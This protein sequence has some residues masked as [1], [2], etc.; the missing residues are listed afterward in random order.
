VS[1]IFEPTTINGLQL[2]NRLVRSATWEGLANEEG[3]VTD[4]LI[5]IYKNL[6]LGQVGLIIS[7]YI[8]VKSDGK[9]W[10]SQIG[11]DND[12]QIPGL[13]R[14]AD[15]VHN[16]GGRLI[17]QIVHCGGQASRKASGDK[18]PVAPSA[19]E[20]PG[21]SEM[22]R[23]LTLSEI[24]DLVACFTSAANR[25]KRANFDGV[26]LHC[27]H[28]YLLSEFLSPSRNL[29]R[30]QFGGNIE[31]RCRFA[32]EIYKSI[33]QE[34]GPSFPVIIKLNAND[35][36]ENSTT[37]TDASALAK[38]LVD[39]GLDA[40][41]ISGGT[42]GSGAM[43]PARSD[44]NSYDQE[45]YFLP[46]AKT[47][48]AAVPDVPLML[49]GG[50]RSAKK[51]ESILETGIADYFSMSR[52]LIRQPHLP[53]LWSEDNTDKAACVSCNQCFLPAM[54]GNGI[55]CLKLKPEAR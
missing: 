39:E 30:D 45:A 25:L 43:G 7:S 51:I 46:Q 1:Q 31:N 3:H 11:A 28:G 22:P 14:L 8:Y 55:K 19:V 20:S 32:T 21:Y 2:K 24:D 50:I 15:E 52:P 48:R 41:E 42:P 16:S 47:I 27:A 5:S 36:L 4:E 49:V 6:A 33:R 37:E 40:I 26:Q 29:R 18:T 35:F 54:R 12:K 34:V 17:G 10:D 13:R 9:Q 38:T 44:V 53:R 23:E